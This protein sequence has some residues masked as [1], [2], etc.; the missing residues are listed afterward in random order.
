MANQMIALQV[1][2]PQTPGLGAAISQNAQLM[3]MMSQQ[4]ASQRQAQ[5]AQQA[6][7]IEAAKEARAVRMEAPQ[8]AKAQAEAA[9]ADIKTAMDFNEFVRTA[10]SN[11]DS[12][13]QVAALATRIAGLPQ[14]QSPLFQVE[15]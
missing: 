8:F 14:F 12:P 11:S 4:R 2:P 5:Q 7:D 1:R 13:D 10:L 6:M 15:K 3:N 9:G